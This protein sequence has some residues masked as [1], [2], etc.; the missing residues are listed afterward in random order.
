MELTAKR[1]SDRLLE[2]LARKKVWS[3]RLLA[4]LFLLPS[5]L[6][7]IL[8]IYWP[9]VQ[10]FF[11]SFLNW[12]M[13]SPN[14]EWVGLENYQT[15]LNMPEFWQGL[16][17]TMIYVGILLVLNLVAPYFCAFALLYGVN[18]FREFYR[19]LLFLPSMLSMAVASMVFLWIFNPFVGPI[20]EI[21]RRMGSLPID[22]LRSADWVIPVITVI[23]AWRAFGQHFIL[24]LAGMISIPKELIE[25][26]QLDGM[27]KGEIFFRIIF[28]LCSPTT[29]YVATITVVLGLQAVFVPIQMLT[30]GG[31][32]QGSTNLIFFVYQTAFQFFHTG[33]AAACAIMITLVFGIL[34][35]LQSIFL[36]KKVHY[37]N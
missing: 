10:T 3:T 31:P 30:N 9:L 15:L 27:G 19:S 12:N 6:F 36:E 14:K 29:L 32:N 24:V 33:R 5:L 13:V 21:M 22:F 37:E 18:H 7:L 2:R 11:L 17:N 23:A 8:F 16:R 26:A 25:A 34:I 28:P 4:G 20:G 35:A 1:N